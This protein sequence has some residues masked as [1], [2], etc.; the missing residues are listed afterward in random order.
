MAIFGVGNL[1]NTTIGHNGTSTDVI[2]N[3]FFG[4]L[5]LI[6]SPISLLLNPIV[7]LYSYKQKLTL[8]SGLFLILSATDFIFSFRSISTTYNL[9]KPELEPL[10]DPHPSLYQRFQATLGYT[11]GYSSMF[12]TM[13]MC[14]VR[15]VKI[16]A[17]FW[18]MSNK[19]IVTSVALTA[20]AIDL[21]YCLTVGILTCCFLSDTWFSVMQGLI[22]RNDEDETESAV[23]S[24]LTIMVPFYIKIGFSVLFSLLTVIHL[25]SDQ[26]QSLPEMK[27]RSV[28]TIVLLNVG[29]LLWFL[30]G[31]VSNV[32]TESSDWEWDF[33][34][35]DHWC[36]EF[37]YLTFFESVIAQCLLAAYNP[38][39][40]CVRNSGLKAM[41]GNFYRTGRMHVDTVYKNPTSDRDN[42][43]V[44]TDSFRPINGK[45]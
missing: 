4:T 43:V 1:T 44:T 15:Y 10:F 35:D 33:D 32:V 8:V 20:I 11:I 29:N 23:A 14:I 42:S 36:Y 24:Y 12:V 5:L 39:I 45:C 16:K 38:L 6:S 37:F 21:I 25:R 28:V 18:A 9:L 22:K 34:A 17:P 41:L 26:G 19:R 13:T 3:Y 30:S 40:F 7:F 31:V 2:M 27:R